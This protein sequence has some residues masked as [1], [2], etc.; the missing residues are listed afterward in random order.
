MHWWIAVAALFVAHHPPYNPQVLEEEAGNCTKNVVSVQARLDSA[1]W[2]QAALDLQPVVHTPLEGP[3]V[4]GPHQRGHGARGESQERNRTTLEAPNVLVCRFRPSLGQWETQLQ[5][6]KMLNLRNGRGKEKLPVLG[7]GGPTDPELREIVAEIQPNY[8][9]DRHKSEE[10]EQKPWYPKKKEK[11]EKKPHG[12]AV[13]KAKETS[14]PQEVHS[15]NMEFV[16]AIKKVYPELSL[17][18][19]ELREVVEKHTSQ[20]EQPQLISEL[21][22]A[23]TQ[24]DKNQKLMQSLKDARQKHRASWLDHMAS[25]MESWKKQLA[26]FE[27]QQNDYNSRLTAARDE[28]RQARNAIQK[29]NAQVGGAEGSSM[30]TLDENGEMEEEPTSGPNPGILQEQ[31]TELLERCIRAAEA[32]QMI[33]VD[34]DLDEPKASEPARKRSRSAERSSGPDGVGV[35]VPP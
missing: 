17:M 35:P 5:H 18:P 11:K 32:P 30:P 34:E 28:I 9:H 13:D 22:K 12:E 29:L 16:A 6:A 21:R 31:A 2:Q 24:L 14:T 27:K 3:S 33:E 26:A 4:P 1:F 10:R 8:D 25:N 20:A 7:I 19:S 15:S 23:T